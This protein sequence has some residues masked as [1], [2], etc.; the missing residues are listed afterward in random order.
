[1]RCARVQF[2]YED[3]V[4]GTLP[5]KTIQ[6][7]EE[8]VSKCS[9]C[10]E[11]YESND[12]VADL[13][14]HA[15][16]AHPGE[17]YVEDLSKRVLS[18]VLDPRTMT[19]DRDPLP[20]LGSV[21]PW[22]RPI[23]WAGAAAAAALLVFGMQPEPEVKLQQ[24][25]AEL[26]GVEEPEESPASRLPASPLMDA[27]HAPRPRRNSPGAGMQ[28]VSGMQRQVSGPAVVTAVESP[29]GSAEIS[30]SV[31]HPSS[32]LRPIDDQGESV[33]Q[34]TAMF[35][36]FSNGDQTQVV[37]QA[38]PTRR[39]PN[40]QAQISNSLMEQIIILDVMGTPESKKKIYEILQSLGAS[41]NVSLSELLGTGN[42]ILLKQWGIF[43]QAEE[44]YR[45][46]RPETAIKLYGSILQIDPQTALAQRANM[47]IADLY[48]QVWG[49]FE[50]ADEFYNRCGGAA[51]QYA[52]TPQ[53]TAHIERRRNLLG[54][55]AASQW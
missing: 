17:P 6:L 11:Y 48:Y 53:E 10:R 37:I 50:R 18:S 42:P 49:D 15:D 23:W 3:Y 24:K 20:V 21:R 41:G 43:S 33:D 5:E 13:I 29:D 14:S 44:L 1:M 9:I 25:L 2:L 16:I 30:K 39:P 26:N 51:A 52:F 31:T 32:P 12:D 54:R 28:T 45:Q 8:H 55:Y 22:R 7:V 35:Q 47:R 46:N 34:R 27:L 4:S 38:A 36:I 40:V 19:K